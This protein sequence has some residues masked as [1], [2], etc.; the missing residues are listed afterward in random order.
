MAYDTTPKWPHVAVYRM[1]SK[2]SIYKVDATIYDLTCL[3]AADLMKILDDYWAYLQKKRI[4]ER[5]Y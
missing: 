2:P 3:E 4:K 5:G 1:D